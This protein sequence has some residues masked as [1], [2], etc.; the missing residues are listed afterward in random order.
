LTEQEDAMTKRVH[1]GMGLLTLVLPLALFAAPGCSQKD[2]GGGGKSL[3]AVTWKVASMYPAAWPVVGESGTYFTGQV[4]AATAGRFKVEFSEP[5]VLVPAL[6]AFDAVSKGTVDALWS[7]S[8]HWAGKIPAAALFSSVPFGPAPAEY[9]GWIYQGGGLL[10]WQELYAK[11][12]VRPIPCG[13]A[14]ASGGGWFLDDLKRPDQLRGMK[15][16]MDGMS[17]SVFGKLG[18]TVLELAPEDVISALEKGVLQ[19]AGASVPALDEKLGFQ[20]VAKHAYFPGWQQRALLLE[21]VVNLDK[22]KA[23]APADQQ[24]IESACRDSIVQTLTYG[25][26]NQVSAVARIRAEGVQIQPWPG[27]F[28]RAFRRAFEEVVKEQS[29][30]D[31]DFAKVWGSLARYRAAYAEWARLTAVPEN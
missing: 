20:K 24:M 28:M 23:L 17:G 19:G 1:P 13:L 18:A 26:V 7:S 3:P 5:G 21:L 22:W 14:P 9:L 25:D 15:L 16:R 8:R 30:K 29:A 4:T 10:L 12:N 2:G 31:A 6:E 27:E 11:H